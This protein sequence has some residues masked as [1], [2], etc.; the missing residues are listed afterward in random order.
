MSRSF[1]RWMLA[2]AFAVAG[3]SPAL[4]AKDLVIAVDSNMPHLDPAN[5]ND[6]LSQSVERTMYQGL[7][8]FDKDMKLI[9]ALAEKV[10][11]DETATE[12]VFHLRHGVTFHDGTPFDAE[13]VRANLERVMN[14]DN[15]L[16]RRSL[17]SMVAHVDVLDPYTVKVVLSQPFGAFVNNMAHPGTFMISPKALAQYGKDI[18]THPV[19]TARSNS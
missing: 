4:A 15:H 3:V 14:P 16:S 10:D 19:G 18:A 8:G 7:F 13:A 1:S 12:F 9:P 17:V 11:A 5:T 6:T 2:A